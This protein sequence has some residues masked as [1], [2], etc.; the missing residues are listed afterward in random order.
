MFEPAGRLC[1]VL[2]LLLACGPVVSG[3]LGCADQSDVE[4]RS[5]KAVEPSFADQA[6]AVDAGTSDQIRIDHTT[7]GDAELSHLSGLEEK[8]RRINL[9]KTTI[10]D[11]GLI[12]IARCQNL[13]QLRL[14]SDRLSDDGLKCLGQLQQLRH[15]HLIGAPITDA[16]LVHLELLQG[17]ESLYLDGS[18]VT[19]EGAR[20]L[21]ESLPNTH[22]HIDR[23]HPRLSAG[24]GNHE[25]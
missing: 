14:A 9:S 11:E 7:V 4:P 13:E 3:V 24:G 19:D 25:H 23:A 17:L 12:A 22:L 6:A 16:G 1:T 10:T 15:L 21:S 20:R 18:Q 2:I 8:L 5:G